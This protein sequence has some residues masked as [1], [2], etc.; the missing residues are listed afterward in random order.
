M[1][2]DNCSGVHSSAGGRAIIA[3]FGS[4]YV[5]LSE[6]LGSRCMILGASSV[7]RA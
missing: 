6:R 1:T 4:R 5:R 3:N 7:R 2:T